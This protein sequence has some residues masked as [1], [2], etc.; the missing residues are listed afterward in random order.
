MN[1]K[2]KDEL[3]KLYEAPMPIRKRAFMRKLCPQPVSIRYMLWIQV[4][5]I[6]KWEWLIS[7]ILFGIIVFFSRMNEIVKVF[8]AVLAVMPV[9]AAGSVSESVRSVTYG[10]KELERSAR[11]SVKSVVLAR[12]CIMGVENFLFTCA[13]ALLIQGRFLH[14]IV[15]LLVPYLAAVYLCLVIVRKVSGSEGIFACIG[16]SIGISILT[17]SSTVYNNTWIFHEQYIYVWAAAAV[18]LIYMNLKQS[19]C[20][21]QFVEN[22]AL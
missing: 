11:F 16:C 5:Y 4:S 10:M 7:L 13:C 3:K 14:I 6:S 20:M 18:I 1:K 22:Y 12:M 8:I 15:Y 21:I 9:L 19:R 2:M 17:I